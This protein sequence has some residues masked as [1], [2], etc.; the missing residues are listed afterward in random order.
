M[1]YGLADTKDQFKPYRPP[2]KK[3]KT[4]TNQML[5]GLAYTKDQFKPYRPHTDLQKTPQNPYRQNVI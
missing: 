3:Q 5:Y 1:L 4:H 2:E